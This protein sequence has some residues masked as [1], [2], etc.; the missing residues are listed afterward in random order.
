LCYLT[1]SLRPYKAEVIRSSRI[2]PTCAAD[3]AEFTACDYLPMVGSAACAQR[4]EAT[5]AEEVLRK[6]R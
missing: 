3:L 5:V 2:S 1:V 6:R 4:R